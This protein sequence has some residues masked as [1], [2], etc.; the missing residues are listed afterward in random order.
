MCVCVLVVPACLFCIPL[1]WKNAE[2][3]KIVALYRFQPHRSRWILDAYN[4]KRR[5]IHTHTHKHT[6]LTHT[7][8]FF[9]CTSIDCWN[10]SGKFWFMRM[11]AYAAAP[12]HLHTHTQTIYQRHIYIERWIKAENGVTSREKKKTDKKC[13]TEIREKYEES[14]GVGMMDA[15]GRMRFN[16]I[17]LEI[18]W[19]YALNRRQ[20]P[21]T[22]VVYWDI[23][24]KGS[25]RKKKNLSFAMLATT[26]FGFVFSSKPRF[27]SNYS[28]KYG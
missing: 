27:E 4:Q 17:M 13:L 22:Q 19:K 9:L 26:T 20:R 25:E 2:Y 1:G 24:S 15:L 6:S 21:K 10:L 28:S 18:F 7:L 23:S 12:I 8:F 5:L 16:W 3:V 11:R 14:V